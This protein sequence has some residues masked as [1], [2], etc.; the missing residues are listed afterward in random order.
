MNIESRAR[1]DKQSYQTFELSNLS[2]NYGSRMAGC[3]VGEVTLARQILG[4]LSRGMLCLAD[5]NFYGYDLWKEAAQSGADL[6]WR[7][8]KNLKLP[9]LQRLERMFPPSQN[10][11]SIE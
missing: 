2:P 7:V 11:F 3:R 9:C 5:R 4:R 6:L 8:K 1:W 10:T